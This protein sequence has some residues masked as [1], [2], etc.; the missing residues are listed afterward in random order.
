MEAAEPD[1]ARGK[2]EKRPDERPG[3]W[4]AKEPL[5]AAEI[6]GL[7]GD[8]AA[9][10][11]DVPAAAGDR[12]SALRRRV[13]LVSRDEDEVRLLRG[14]LG[15]LGIDCSVVRNPFSALDQIRL[16]GFDGVIS[17][18]D[19]WSSSGELLFQRLG[20]SAAAPVVFLCAG[21][22]AAGAARAAGAAEVLR[23]PL[24]PR[25]LA[26][27]AELFGAGRTAETPAAEHPP[28]PPPSIRRRTEL[29][30]PP[31]PRAATP[32]V[33]ATQTAEAGELAWL[34]FFFEV[35]RLLRAEPPG[36]R[37]IPVI[38]SSFA[39]ELGWE[40]CGVAL[41]RED[42][43]WVSVRPGAVE[44]LSRLGAALS[45][46]PPVGPPQANV[47]PS[48]PAAVGHPTWVGVEDGCVTAWWGQDGRSGV[49][50]A[51]P[52]ECGG[53]APVPLPPVP[54]KFVDEL[55]VLIAEAGIG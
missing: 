36:R 15:G 41:A 7:L 51:L 55:A 31:E 47:G 52:P 6:R 32:P 23:R 28:E 35:R 37:R 53:N 13:L 46:G 50:M 26:A 27:A 24:Q 42:T 44:I 17:D 16:R 48:A 29:A 3:E 12:G 25:D 22:E 18:F 39:R 8:E 20:A 1:P 34:R 49:F 10:D 19:L 14:V 43:W 9:A 2:P 5:S 21:A 11:P 30:Q 33:R 38:L 45:V 40:S 4:K 54:R